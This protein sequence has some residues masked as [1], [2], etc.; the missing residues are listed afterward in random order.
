MTDSCNDLKAK[1]DDMEEVAEQSAMLQKKL[2][3]LKKEHDKIIRKQSDLEKKM[4]QEN[5]A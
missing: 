3:Q 2:E 1:L 4:Q 5:L